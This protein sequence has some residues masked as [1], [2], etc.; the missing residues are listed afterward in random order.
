MGRSEVWKKQGE[1]RSHSPETEKTGSDGGI[2]CTVLKEIWG[3]TGLHIHGWLLKQDVGQSNRRNGNNIER[4]ILSQSYKTKQSETKEKATYFHWGDVHDTEDLRY[5][6][7]DGMINS[8]LCTTVAFQDFM[9][10][11][12]VYSMAP[13]FWQSLL[14]CSKE[15]ILDGRIK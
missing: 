5:G 7:K 9:A 4:G 11:M 15:P 12:G 6:G 13:G 3:V 14:S 8:L 10:E 1:S 2:C